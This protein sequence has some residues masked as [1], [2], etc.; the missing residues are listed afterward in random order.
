MMKESGSG[1]KEQNCCNSE[2]KSFSVLF[3]E[4]FLI[5]QE[6]FKKYKLVFLNASGN[7]LFK[8]FHQV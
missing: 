3:W 5:G 1:N 8:W 4:N 2:I 6:L 7:I